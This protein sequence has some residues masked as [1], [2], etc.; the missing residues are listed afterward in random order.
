MSEA[1]RRALR[2]A[3]ALL[4]LVSAARWAWARRGE[5]V[6]PGSSDVLTELTEESARAARDRAARSRPLGEGERID[7]NRA[8][9]QTL[10]RLP[11]IGAGTAA[12][13]VRE[14]E[15]HGGFSEPSDLL[16]VRGIGPSTL[17]R[18][19]PHLDLSQGVPL[20]L[21]RRPRGA[22]LASETTL[23]DLNRASAD[24][25]ETLPGVGPALAARIVE[26]R[27]RRP[28]ASVG[29]LVRVRGIGPSTLERVR[30]RVTVGGPGP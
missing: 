28:F 18:I 14:R 19:A 21:A 25:L 17:E 26:E 20:E 15:S 30:D 6:G 10:D 23:V 9:E 24:E 27:G 12:G 7:P 16:R 1:E 13:I 5:P 11:G 2:R 3:T 4:L 8:S 29:E 22:A